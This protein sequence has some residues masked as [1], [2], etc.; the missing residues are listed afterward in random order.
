[1]SVC[2]SGNAAEAVRS[3]KIKVAKNKGKRSSSNPVSTPKGIITLVKNHKYP[4]T[5]SV[6]NLPGQMSWAKSVSRSVIL[7]FDKRF[8]SEVAIGDAE[9]V[10]RYYDYLE[11]YVNSSAVTTLEMKEAGEVLCNYA[12]FASYYLYGEMASKMSTSGRKVSFYNAIVT[13]LPFLNRTL[14]FLASLGAMEYFRGSAAIPIYGYSRAETVMEWNR[15][16]LGQLSILDGAGIDSSEN[17]PQNWKRYKE[18]C[19]KAYK[20]T[21]KR[22]EENYSKEDVAL[23][24]IP[25]MLSYINEMDEL[26]Q[27]ALSGYQ[28]W[29]AECDLGPSGG[30]FEI[31]MGDLLKRWKELVK[32]SASDG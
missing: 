26:A 29:I 11:D 32:A 8:P 22:I 19:S 21:H 7:S 6:S 5:V 17:L 2:V 31:T 13:S 28:K 14:S 25:S 15:M 18:E 10:L 3:S 16:L 4:S 27:T 1:M 24:D 9:K 20:E 30:A 23:S 12:D